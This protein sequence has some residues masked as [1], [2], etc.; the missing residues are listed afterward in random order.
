MKKY[1]QNQF[2]F[3][4]SSQLRLPVS[5]SK[6]VLINILERINNG[7]VTKKELSPQIERCVEYYHDNKIFLDLVL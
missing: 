2:W 3:A 6:K 4:I 5:D 7:K 1:L